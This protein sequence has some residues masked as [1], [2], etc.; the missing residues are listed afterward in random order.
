[1]EDGKV[2]QPFPL[3][4][5]GSSAGGLR[6]GAS[7]PATRGGRTGSMCA[8]GPDLCADPVRSVCNASRNSFGRGSLLPATL[9]ATV[10]PSGLL[11]K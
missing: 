1:V 6:P 7:L 11:R 10:L 4:S 3:P 8:T 2:L 9:S 5:P